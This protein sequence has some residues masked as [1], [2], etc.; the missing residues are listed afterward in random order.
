MDIVEIANQDLGRKLQR[1]E[2]GDRYEGTNIAKILRQIYTARKYT[3]YFEISRL[4]RL[5]I[6]EARE[7]LPNQNRSFRDLECF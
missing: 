3:L 2:S 6:S 7:D 4:A 5:V 1:R